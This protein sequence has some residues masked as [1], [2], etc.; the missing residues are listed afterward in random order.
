MTDTEQ[1]SHWFLAQL[2]PNGHQLAERNLDRQGFRHFLPM[3][4]ESRRKRGR[5]ITLLRPL[6]PGYIFIAFD[7]DQGLWRK[8]NSTNGVARLVSFGKSPAPVPA[9]LINSLMARCDPAGKF[10]P[11]GTVAPGDSVRIAKG[12]FADFVATVEKLAPDN[13]VFVLLDLMGR[14]TRITVAADKLR[15]A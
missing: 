7:P 4:E 3:Q 14:K 8:I 15:L 2:K 12:P 10:L 6:F 1:N 9:E 13:R 11:T 5:F